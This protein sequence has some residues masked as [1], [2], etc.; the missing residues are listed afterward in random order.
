[1]HSVHVY[2]EHGWIEVMWKDACC[3]PKEGR[4]KG[5]EGVDV[6]AGG[7]KCELLLVQILMLLP[8]HSRGV[9]SLF[10]KRKR[11]SRLHLGQSTF[12]TLRLLDKSVSIRLLSC[13]VSTGMKTAQFSRDVP[14]TVECM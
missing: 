4:E 11:M 14:S 9:L 10:D 6:G 3:V 5:N 8:I 2:A 12:L 7:S 13:D 1:M